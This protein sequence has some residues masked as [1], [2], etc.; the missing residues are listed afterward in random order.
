[1]DATRRYFFSLLVGLSLALISTPTHA[2]YREET[3]ALEQIYESRARAALNTLL[4][5]EEYSIVVAAEIERDQ[6]RLLA[7]EEDMDKMFLPGVPG[8]QMSENLPIANRLHEL[9]NRIDVVLVLHSEVSPEQ[10]A[11]AK[12]LV[13]MKLQLDESAGDTLTVSRALSLEKTNPPSPDVLPELSWRMWALILLLGLLGTGMVLLL[14]NRNKKAAP[15]PQFMTAPPSKESKEETPAS[16]TPSKD[17]TR[18]TSEATSAGEEDQAQLVELY[19]RK[20]SLIA[21]AT[22]YPEAAAAALAEHF[23]KGHEKD[24]L[25]TCEALG[26]ELSKK[27]FRDLSHRAWARLGMMISSRAQDP[28]P[29]E[30]LEAGL[31]PG[32]RGT[33]PRSGRG[34]RI[35]SVRLSQPHE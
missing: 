30:F 24:L 9:R 31:S 25:L 28:T 17:E 23:A 4:R 13:K 10:E 3:G 16:E 14:L 21:L 6:K 5:P 1:M 34:R 18:A 33:I 2:Q 8:L 26:W 20:K 12:S 32:R 29:Q 15:P 22:Q 7:L 35:E 11:T 19:E 27:V